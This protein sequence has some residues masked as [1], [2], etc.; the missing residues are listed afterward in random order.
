MDIDDTKKTT[1]KRLNLKGIK[2][3]RASLCML[4]RLYY[5]KGIDHTYFKNLVY[6][7]SKLLEHD[8]HA[9]E[10]ETNKRLD[11]LEQ[12]I[13]GEQSTLIDNKEINSPYT[14][15]LK[16]QLQHMEK[17]NLEL[18]TELLNMKKEMLKISIGNCDE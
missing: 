16:K 8:K 4:M 13:K 12:F 7:Y 9:L 5:N 17:T 15:E 1:P 2:A 18:Q 3:T 6:S 10:A 14:L 11:A